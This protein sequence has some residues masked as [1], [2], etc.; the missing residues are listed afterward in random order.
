MNYFVNF[1][2]NY[3]G[4]PIKNPNC[5]QIKKR[6]T[7]IKFPPKI[8]HKCG[9][10]VNII[11]SGFVFDQKQEWDSKIRKIPIKQERSEK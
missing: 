9:P 10:N 2:L 3:H 4:F 8:F 7:V 5:F 6:E 11:S 1:N